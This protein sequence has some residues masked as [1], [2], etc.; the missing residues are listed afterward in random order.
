[1]YVFCEGSIRMHKAPLFLQCESLPQADL[2]LAEFP[3]GRTGSVA[4]PLASPVT[5]VQG[6]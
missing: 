5:E 6:G 2:S 3:H 4:G 1:L